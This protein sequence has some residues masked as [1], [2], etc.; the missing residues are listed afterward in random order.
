MDGAKSEEATQLPDSDR[1]VHHFLATIA[2]AV[3]EAA[4]AQRRSAELDNSR[5]LRNEI[6]HAD[7]TDQ[8]PQPSGTER[9][10]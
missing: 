4:A 6:A 9:R 7:T 8:G 2:R 10:P 1:Q 5:A 3:R